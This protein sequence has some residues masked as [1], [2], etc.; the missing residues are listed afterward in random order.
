MYQDGQMKI[1][2]G[3]LLTT[4][5]YSIGRRSLEKY[6][7]CDIPRR[8]AI[9][10]ANKICRNRLWSNNLYHSAVKENLLMEYGTIDGYQFTTFQYDNMGDYVRATNLSYR[11][12]LT[13]NVLST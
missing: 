10:I 5:M 2:S 11:I 8:I 12:R 3:M 7:C 4:L 6:H 1:R 9:R 13:K